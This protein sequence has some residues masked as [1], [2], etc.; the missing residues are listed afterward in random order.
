[1]AEHLSID[2]VTFFNADNKTSFEVHSVLVGANPERYARE[3]LEREKRDGLAQSP[4]CA[5]RSQPCSG[6][7]DDAACRGK[8]T[9]REERAQ[10]NR[11]WRSGADVRNVRKNRA[12]CGSEKNTE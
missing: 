12:C 2:R 7:T 8:P 10:G 5:P 11:G 4:N 1:M 6:A 3:W 9:T